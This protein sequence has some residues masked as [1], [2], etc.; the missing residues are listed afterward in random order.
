MTSGPLDGAGNETLSN[1]SP[2]IDTRLRVVEVGA[3]IPRGIS[4]FIRY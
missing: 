1:S 4:R 3:N 2:E